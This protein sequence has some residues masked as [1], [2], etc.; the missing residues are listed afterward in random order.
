[1]QTVRIETTKKN[2]SAYGG[3]R[4]VD[5]LIKKTEL[6]LNIESKLPVSDKLKKPSWEK[7]KTLLMGFLA[8][9]DCLDD[10]DGLKDEPAFAASTARPYSAKSLGDYLRSFDS[11]HIHDLMES[12]IDLSFKLRT[13]IVDE[14]QDL[15]FDIDSSINR[16]YGNKMEGVVPTY[17]EF[18]GL[19]TLY[20][21]DDLGLEYWHEVRAGS[22][23]SSNS[24][25]L[26]VNKIASLI[27]KNGIY[28]DSRKIFRG[29]SA[30]CTSEFINSCFAKGFGFVCA[31][32][33]QSNF[34]DHLSRIKNWK[35]SS[36]KA[37]DGRDCEIGTCSITY[38]Q[39][40]KPIRLV[41]AR[42]KSNSPHESLFSVDHYDYFGFVT[43]MGQHE[44]ENEDLILSLS[45]EG[46][47]REF[48]QRTKVRSG[49]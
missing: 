33:K 19:D 32:K 5:Q 43:N 20:V 22:T 17:K 30:F 23:Y 47:C 11:A 40:V 37:K 35:P 36:I 42:A 12:L 2:I 46:A 25:S 31:Y 21:H 26:A 48:H 39:A 27:P 34:Y 3:L 4:L 14:G 13:E 44:Y 24:C 15:I 16:Q 28:K 41:V 10:W 9:A 45:Q 1:M 6:R 8:G 7:F 49:P 38:A 29:G 18:E